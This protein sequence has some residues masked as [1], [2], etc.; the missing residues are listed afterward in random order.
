MSERRT[1][2]EILVSL[3]KITEDDVQRALEHQREHGGFFGEALVAAGIVNEDELEYGLA[4]QFDLPYVFP[5]PDSVD[6]AAAALVSPEWALANLTLPILRTEDTVRV[7]LASPSRAHGLTELERRTGLQVEP[8]LASPSSIRELIRQV[9]ARAS[10]ADEGQ[11]RPI[12]L[13][14]MLDEVSHAEAPRF[15]ISVRGARAHAWWDDAGVIRR[16]P[17]AGDWT[18]ALDRV[19]IPGP[20]ERTR[21]RERA[22]WD[23]EL[24]GDGPAQPVEVRYLSDESGCEFLFRPRDVGGGLEERFPVP[25]EG[26]VSEIGLLARAGRARF[27]VTTEPEELGHQMLPHLPALVLDPSW[28][29]IY[30]A[31]EGRAAEE[32]AFSLRMPADPETWAEEIEALRAFHFDVVTADLGGSDRRWATSALDVGSVAFLLWR[33][34]EDPG[35]AHEAG[36]RWHLRIEHRAEGDTEWSLEPLNG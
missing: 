20:S 18:A 29:S 26:I 25:P 30:I 2:G 7:V 24:H 5:D 15:G 28:R 36:V 13:A 12:E 23:G 1:I 19:L 16:R 3:G 21:E 10:A 8:A 35:P 17:L 14:E 33:V 22:A 9:Y 4:S 32:E 34:G 31:T 27:I 11:R 6:P